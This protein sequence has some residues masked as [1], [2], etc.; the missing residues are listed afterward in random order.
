MITKMAKTLAIM[1]SVFLML[2]LPDGIFGAREDHINKI[3]VFV[4][5]Y[6][7][8]INN[9]RGP[10]VLLLKRSEHRE[11]YPNLWECIG[12][13]VRENESLEAAAKRQ[14]KEETGINATRWKLSECFEIEVSPGVIV[15]G[16]AFS[17]K[18]DFDVKIKLDPKE[19]VDYRWVRLDEL[20]NFAIVS[21]NMH[22]SIVKL[23]MLQSKLY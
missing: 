12:G 20:E 17:C 14:L 16:V 11:L 2:L 23:L 21:K 1:V 15:P 7:Y 6:C 19:H 4:S 22:Q 3:E 13:S 9:S 5:A 10:E 18:A 8:R